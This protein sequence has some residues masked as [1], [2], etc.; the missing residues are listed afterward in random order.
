MSLR[1]LFTAFLC[2]GYSY[3]LQ[4]AH[5]KLTNALHNRNAPGLPSS[6]STTNGDQVAKL[7]TYGSVTALQLAKAQALVDEAHVRIGRANK[8]LH[9]N[10][11]RNTYDKS[12]GAPRTQRYIELEVPYAVSEEITTAVAMLAEYD[13]RNSM[14]STT[15]PS[16]FRK[17]VAPFWM[18]SIKHSGSSPFGN[19][20]DYKVRNSSL[21]E[22]QTD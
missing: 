16:V 9:E 14:N 10:P 21:R 3:A 20:P 18:E 5:C 2:F 8:Y 4:D 19:D 1:R 17:R 12:D 15:V 22:I 6:L 7:P 13:A 11:R